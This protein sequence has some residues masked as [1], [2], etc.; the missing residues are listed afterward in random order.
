MRMRVK[1]L[2][3]VLFILCLALGLFAQVDSTFV[4]YYSPTYETHPYWYSFPTSFALYTL[5]TQPG[6][7]FWFKNS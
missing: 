4:R 3:G 7:I 2:G 5:S 6:E 1:K